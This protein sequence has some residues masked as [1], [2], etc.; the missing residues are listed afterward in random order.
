MTHT[1]RPM[2]GAGIAQ[3]QSVCRRRHAQPQYL[4]RRFGFGRL[5]RSI[6]S[7]AKGIAA[8]RRSAI[9]IS[10]GSRSVTTAVR[11]TATAVSATPAPTSPARHNDHLERHARPDHRRHHDHQPERHAE[12][13]AAPTRRCGAGSRS[14]KSNTRRRQPHSSMY[15]KV[16]IE[17]LEWIVPGH[18]HADVAVITGQNP[19]SRAPA[20]PT[21]WRSSNIASTAATTTRSARLDGK[22]NQLWPGK[23]N[24]NNSGTAG[25]QKAVTGVEWLQ[26][27]H[28][29]QSYVIPTHTERAGP[30]NPNSSA[31]YNIEHFRDLNNAGPTVAFGIELP[32]HLAQG[33]DQRRL[34]FLQHRRG[35]RR[36]LRDER[37]LHREGRRAVGRPARRRPQFLHLCQLRLA[38]PRCG[39]VHATRSRPRL[40]PGRVHQAL[41]PERQRFQGAIDDRRHAFGQLVFGQRRH[42]RSGSRFPG[43]GDATMSGRPWAKRWS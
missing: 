2:I 40:H 24:V 41:R 43:Q 19:R 33:G 38:Q 23:D 20:T 5:L 4:H 28:P 29:L 1:L 12:R 31:G 6:A 9:S 34:R 27:H 35:R 37:H 30:F 39:S 25:H 3:R 26:R 16:L 14:R 42:R 10:T 36:H 13:H 21:T 32:G 8:G 17:G 22:N 15:N 11:A 7:V 18:E